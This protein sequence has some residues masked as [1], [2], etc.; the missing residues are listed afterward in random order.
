MAAEPECC[1][2]CRFYVK[3]VTDE[4]AAARARAVL[5]MTVAEG[6]CRRY[7]TSVL[8][9]AGDWCGEYAKAE[10]R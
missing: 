1:Q 3:R 7:P 9:S 5:G 8:R 4:R 6:H 2:L 10:A